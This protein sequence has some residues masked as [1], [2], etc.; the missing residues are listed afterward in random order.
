[1]IGVSMY[2]SHCRI[3]RVF[4]NSMQ[5]IVGTVG[6]AREYTPFE[7]VSLETTGSL[8]CECRRDCLLFR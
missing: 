8:G 6:G 3:I 2:V 5:H 4:L 7:L 1:M